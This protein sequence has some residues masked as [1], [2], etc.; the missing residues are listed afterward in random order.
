M[1]KETALYAIMLSELPHVGDRAAHRILALNQTRGH[2]L[3]TFFRLPPAVLRDDYRLAPST[4]ARLGAQRTEH[5]SRCRWLLDQLVVAGGT[6]ALS[7]DAAYPERLRRR[8]QPLPAVL[9]GCGAAR[10]L[11][12]PTL[13]VLTSRTLSEHSV[14]AS[15]AVVQAAA[16]QGFTLVSGGMKANYRIAA[17][18]GRAAAAARVI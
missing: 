14:A 11:E 12:P 2:G 1:D 16:R 17:V 9:Y 13:A 5:E 7:D 18:A 6:V 8:L 3:A 15:L 4:V 10:V